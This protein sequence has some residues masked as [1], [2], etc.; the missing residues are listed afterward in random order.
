MWIE[1]KFCFLKME[2]S[3]ACLSGDGGDLSRGEMRTERRQL[4]EQSPRKGVR[5]Q[6]GGSVG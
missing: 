1:G 2:D 6:L 3:K 4:Q 5:G